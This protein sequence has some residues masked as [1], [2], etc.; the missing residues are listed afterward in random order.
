ML[1]AGQC[2]IHEFVELQYKGV[3]YLNDFLDL[4]KFILF[5]F[6]SVG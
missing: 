5:L 3:T 2:L 6:Y 4:E 1:L